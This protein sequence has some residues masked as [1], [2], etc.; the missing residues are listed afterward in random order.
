MWRGGRDGALHRTVN[1]TCLHKG[2]QISPPALQLEQERLERDVEIQKGVYLTLKQ[3]LEL[4]K[5][6]EVQETS[7]VQILD[8][9][10][11][12]FNP[13]NKNLVLSVV[14]SLILGG[15]LGIMIGFI[16]SY[17]DNNDMEE[18][19]KLRR[20][21]HFLKKKIKDI[22]IDRRVSGVV[23]FFMLSGLPFFLS[24]KSKTPVYFGMYSSKLLLVNI[25]YILVLFLLL[26][27][28]IY[29]IRNKD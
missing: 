3:Q 11:V 14:L 26:G 18:R 2:V 1:P 29:Q 6:E 19:K 27:V 5:I 17:M 7:V 10:T 28:F 25:I 21:K 15:G 20:I 24:Y 9:P 13:S 8:R 22:F 16:R 23:S 12:A 4:A